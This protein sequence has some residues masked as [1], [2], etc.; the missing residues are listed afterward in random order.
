MEMEQMMV[1]QGIPQAMVPNFAAYS[2]N[3]LQPIAGYE[4]VHFNIYF[5][6]I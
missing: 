5:S 1:S 4:Q 3:L 6:P 2:Q